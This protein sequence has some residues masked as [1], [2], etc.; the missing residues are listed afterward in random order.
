MNTL[1]LTPEHIKEHMMY[2]ILL[3]IIDNTSTQMI[4]DHLRTGIYF[5]HYM[6]C[7]SQYLK[8]QVNGAFNSIAK[9]RVIKHI[10]HILDLCNIVIP[11]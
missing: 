7:N 4:I 10:N 11:L 9:S 2:N 3:I 6:L 8:S 5:G 1:R